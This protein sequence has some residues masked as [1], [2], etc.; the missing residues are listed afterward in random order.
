MVPT[1]VILDEIQTLLATDVAT[2][3]AAA[4]KHVHLIK[5]PFTPGPQT[6]LSGLTPADFTGSTAKNAASGNQQQFNDPI[7]V[8]L[9]VQLVEPLGGW[10]WQA[11]DAVNLPQTIFGF[12]VTDLANA[13]TFGSALLDTPVQLLAAGDA[14]D[15]GNIRFSFVAPVVE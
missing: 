10:H 11:T 12:V 4:A 5:A 3:A 8:Q 14:V 13:V 7:T 2:L 1:Q 6:A 9:V 15:V